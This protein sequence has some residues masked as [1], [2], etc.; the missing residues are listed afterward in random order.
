MFKTECVWVIVDI[1]RISNC[2]MKA[3]IMRRE[4]RENITV[5]TI[6]TLHE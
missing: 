6:F 1:E 5:P 4:G 2:I 3:Q